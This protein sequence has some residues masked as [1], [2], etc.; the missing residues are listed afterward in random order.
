[1]CIWQLILQNS[2]LDVNP[3]NERPGFGLERAS[4]QIIKS[5]FSV[6]FLA[7]FLFKNG[8]LGC[9]KLLLRAGNGDMETDDRG[10]TLLHHAA[11]HGQ[12]R[13]IKWQLIKM[14]NLSHLLAQQ[15]HICT[16]TGCWF[17][18]IGACQVGSRE[19]P[20]ALV[21]WSGAKSCMTPSQTPS[22]SWFVWS[23]GWSCF[24]SFLCFA[25]T[26][27]WGT[28]QSARSIPS[29]YSHLP[30]VQCQIAQLQNTCMA[31]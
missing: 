10:H 9:L 21:V 6:F 17:E 3:I 8:H 26:K 12:V 27:A 4:W 1:M 22:S 11:Y 30:I 23:G 5:S 20:H 16:Q 7:F 19:V 15:P 13:Q 31:C 25:S 18:T 14:R 28:R 24:F 2:L 29:I